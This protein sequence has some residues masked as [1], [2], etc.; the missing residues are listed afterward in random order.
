MCK[1][2]EC[3]IAQYDAAAKKPATKKK[4]AAKKPAT[5]KKAVAK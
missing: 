5:K 3:I 4:T 1:N 2:I